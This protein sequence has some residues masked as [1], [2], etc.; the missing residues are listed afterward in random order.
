MERLRKSFRRNKNKNKES[1]NAFEIQSVFAEPEVDAAAPEEKPPTRLQKIRNSMRIKKKKKEKEDV[2]VIDKE[3]T[4]SEDKEDP[5]E[6]IDSIPL[7]KTSKLRASLRIRKK[8]KTEKKEKKEK[9]DKKK[10]SSKWETDDERVRSNHCEFKVKYLGNIEVQ[11]SRGMEVCESAIKTLKSSKE[12]KV[13]GT[14][15]V[16]GDGLRVVDNK[17]KGM[18]VDQ[19]IEKVSFCAPD[20]NYSRGFA[21]ISRDG[22]SRRWVCHGFMARK[23]TGERLS[24]AVGVAFAVCLEKKQS[25]ECEGVTGSYNEEEGTFTRFGSFRQGTLTERLQNPQEFKESA[26]K[27]EV[28]VV[29][30]PFAIARPRPGDLR[31][32]MRGLGEI[33]GASPFKRG[34]Q[35]YTSLRVNDLPSNVS[36]KEKS[37]VSLIL[38]ETFENEETKNEINEMILQMSKVKLAQAAVPEPSSTAASTEASLAE[39]STPL[40]PLKPMTATT[41]ATTKAA[42]PPPLLMSKPPSGPSTQSNATT[43]I[44][45]MNNNDTGFKAPVL[46]GSAPP[47]P[48]K[49]PPSPEGDNPWD[50][51][52]DQP[53]IKI[54][55]RSNSKT[56]NYKSEPNPPPQPPTA[57]PADRWLASLTNKIS[58]VEE[59]HIKSWEENPKK[60]EAWNNTNGNHVEDPLEIEWA[61]LANRNAGKD[62]PNGNNTNPFRAFV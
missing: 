54:H 7:E 19:V 25:R 59:N 34:G 51:V 50:L 13:K 29:E 27:V 6:E 1:E 31:A 18:L 26:K 53:K 9:K 39:L 55:S 21:Y 62:A 28:G 40:S 46:N 20:R 41:P 2:I 15:H 12:K 24:H 57:N 56:D 35:E 16:S 49:V 48:A 30:N 22:T 17:K 32:S 33:K 37:R 45:Q 36:R 23:D 4:S 8:D 52:P 47:P 44:F 61:A 42:P 11:E 38:E 5:K 58:A 60:V 43:A 3:T 10:G 14:L